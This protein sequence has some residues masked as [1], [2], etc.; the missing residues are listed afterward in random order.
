V[1]VGWELEAGW[2]TAW[3]F[4]T[5][6]FL[7]VIHFFNP[8]PAGLHGPADHIVRLAFRSPI[9]MLELFWCYALS[10][11]KS[12]AWGLWYAK[13]NSVPAVHRVIYWGVILSTTNM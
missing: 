12:L 1:P 9:N 2:L 10:G 8:F 5:S 3:G 7:W 11:S 6:M 4:L 13:V